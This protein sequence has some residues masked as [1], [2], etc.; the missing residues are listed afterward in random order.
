MGCDQVINCNGNL[1][2]QRDLNEYKI[3]D[4]IISMWRKEQDTI[5][6]KAICGTLVKV[7]TKFKLWVYR[8]ILR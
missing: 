3:C 1:F 6:Y 7:V 8:Y 5:R 4:K 2:I